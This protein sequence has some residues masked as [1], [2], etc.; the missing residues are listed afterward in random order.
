[1]ATCVFFFFPL[2]RNSWI[3][4]VKWLLHFGLDAKTHAKGFH[5]IRFTWKII[6]D[7]I[8]HNKDIAIS[9]IYQSI[10]S[11]FS[12][13]TALFTVCFLCF[14]GMNNTLVIQEKG[15]GERF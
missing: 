1:M 3:F 14:N 10:S 7:K 2:E 13:F 11:L 9:T 12:V 15:G 4:W 6:T 8:I 5:N